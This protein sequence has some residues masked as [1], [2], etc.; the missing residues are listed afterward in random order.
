MLLSL[1]DIPGLTSHAMH[2]LCPTLKGIDRH[3]QQKDT[4]LEHRRIGEVNEGSHD[5]GS[6]EASSWSSAGTRL[7]LI[8][9]GFLASLNTVRQHGSSTLKGRLSL[10]SG[11]SL[12]GHGI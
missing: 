5:E 6:V 7:H 11:I 9:S 8:E 3:L 4:A 1:G 12:R 10:R 2:T